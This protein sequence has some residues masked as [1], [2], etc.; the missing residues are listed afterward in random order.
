M[1]RAED[2]L[3]I[4]ITHAGPADRELK[5]SSTAHATALE[6]Q[7]KKVHSSS[8][9]CPARIT[10]QAEGA[11]WNPPRIAQ[12]WLTLMK[13]LGYT[14]FTAQG[15]DWGAL[16][17][18]I[19]GVMAPPELVAIHTNMP[20]TVP[21]EIYQALRNGSGPPTGLS[22][23]ELRAYDRL[24]LFFTHGLGYAN[25][26]GQRPQTLY[27]IADSPVGLAAWF[28]DHDILSYRMIVRAFDA[29]ARD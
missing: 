22:A 25:Q 1:S 20:S 2:A 15:G 28:L 23:E 19:L 24:E 12:A 26:M 9:R 17:T 10:R 18:E 11:G 7:G 16:M 27:G 6:G 14:R 21:P 3:P 5:K 13:R 29:R 4:I 8:R